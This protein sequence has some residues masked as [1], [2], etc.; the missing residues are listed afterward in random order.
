MAEDEMLYLAEGNQQTH[1][2]DQQ[3]K[4]PVPTAPPNAHLFP[5]HLKRPAEAGDDHESKKRAQPSFSPPQLTPHSSPDDEGHQKEAPSDPLKSKGNFME[6]SEDDRRKLVKISL[7]TDEGNFFLGFSSYSPHHH[8]AREPFLS[9]LVSM[10]GVVAPRFS[11]EDLKR[12][13]TMHAS[14]PILLRKQGNVTFC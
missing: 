1:P 4:D 3:M 13:S 12:A 7:V 5:G 2:K 10:T 9:S 8:S 11:I 6:N 14:G